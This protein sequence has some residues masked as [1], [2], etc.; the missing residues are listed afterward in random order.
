MFK[1]RIQKLSVLLFHVFICINL[2]AQNT[3]TKSDMS[4]DFGFTRGRNINIWPLFKKYKDSEKKE[5]QI[6][7]PL[8]S[9]MSNYS[10]QTKHSHLLPIF[11]SD[12]TKYSNDIR[13]F[14]FYYPSVFH[15]EITRN[16]KSYK[17]LEL[18]PKITCLGISRN[19]KGLLLENNLF[20]FLWYKHDTTENKT[21]LVAF[22]LYW[23]NSSS[24][25]TSQLFLPF[26]YKYTSKYKSQLNIALLYNYIR[27]YNEIKQSFFPIWWSSREYWDTDTLKRTTIFPIYW[28]TKDKSTNN[29]TYFPFVYYRNKNNFKHLTIFPLFSLG[30]SKDFTKRYFNIYPFYWSN[31]NKVTTNKTFFPFIF[32]LKNSTYQSFT[33][34]PLFS[35]G[36]S[37][38]SSINHFV[39]SPLF[40]HLKSSDKTS[41]IVFPLWWS[42]TSF[43]KNDTTKSKTLFP[44]FWFEK[45]KNA[46]KLSIFPCIFKTK[47]QYNSSF[48]IFPF[49][50]LWKT[51]D[52]DSSYQAFIPFYF[53]KKIP[54]TDIK[55]IFPVI[56]LSKYF[57]KDDTIK[58]SMVFP[59]Y[60]SFKSKIKN[61]KILFPIF[62][63]LSN[64][65]NTSL[66]ILPLF[67]I[68]HSKD[69]T[70]KYFDILPVF[71][72]YKSKERNNTILFPIWWSI[73]K[74]LKND[75]IKK[76]IVFPFVWMEKSSSKNNLIVFPFV[77][78]FNNHNRKSLTVFP[79]YSK[80]KSYLNDSCF[81][82]IFPIYWHI[83]DSRINQHIVFPIYWHTVL[84]KSKDTIRKTSFIPFYWS[85][86]SRNKNNT[87]VF[88]MVYSLKD[89]TKKSLTVF[90]FFS[91]GITSDSSKKYLNIFPF[92]WQQQNKY[93]LSKVLF[94][95]WWQFDNFN[96]H[97]TIKTRTV[98]PFY[99]STHSKS[100]NNTI[101]FPIV[102]NLKNEF[103]RTLTII[104]FF[105]KGKSADSSK[106]Y[107]TVFPIWWQQK[108][109]FQSSSVL[110]P[111]WWKYDYFYKHD[112]IKTRTAFPFFW[113]KKSKTDNNT[114][115]FPFVFKLK[116]ENNSSLTVLPFFSKG[117]TAN[118]KKKYLAI[119]PFWWSNTEVT[120]YDT[121]IHKTFI[122][123][124]WSLK[125][126][127]H[128]SVIIF[129]LFKHTKTSDYKSNILFP[130]F[131]NE[132]TYSKNDTTFKTSLFPIYWSKRSKD[133]NNTVLFPIL[134]KFKDRDYK[135]LTVFPLFS[136][137]Q[138]LIDNSKYLILTPL[139]G[140]IQSKQKVHSYLFPIFNYKREN[141]K[142]QTSVFL[143]LY[144]RKTDLNYSKTSILWPI[145][146]KEKSKNF[147]SF[148][149]API[150]W[151]AKTDTSKMFSIQPFQYSYKSDTRKTFMLFWFLYRYNNVFDK[152]ISHDILWKFFNSE[153]CS[154]GEFETRFLYLLYANSDKD[155]KQE[156][157][158][159]PFYHYVNN[160]NGDKTVS[161]FFGFY[162][163]F[164]QYKSELKA[165]YEEERIFW[166]IRLRSNYDKLKQEGKV[167]DF[168][169]R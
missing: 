39:V 19:S 140:I 47:N 54:N 48:T 51:A 101:L 114:T 27:N 8:F 3:E 78:K 45:S 95:L 73:D 12:S 17:F 129:P 123:F 83:K 133:V 23:Y 70:K 115:L 90:P 169:R 46:S 93:Q 44:I 159:F 122:P 121:L 103:E 16:S 41:N 91:K 145:C 158:I 105:S 30:H 118:S 92:W 152:S 21:R 79:F 155:G 166:L 6:L 167:T 26:Y 2:L 141:T 34:F 42:K 109:K 156:K 4:F 22:P 64:K 65:Q 120:L 38:D 33:F 20:F 125:S 136:K 110:F 29:K 97:D 89:S 69:S 111:L 100:E 37:R 52:M 9:K 143:F 84:S 161:V 35:K 61:N 43:L 87:I 71:W 98:F 124:F 116:N 135:S 151:Y 14:S 99:W 24:Y 7:F 59:C 132:V 56:K 81:W 25:D 149:I 15:F 154:N 63:S 94:P 102:F 131:K 127:H 139:A 138:S 49:Y 142:T 5:L 162:N 107:L 147:S 72:Y 57:L 31:K 77:Y 75:T 146:E 60:W 157:S 137:G 68:G 88:P 13:L 117:N 113:S 128:N 66:T 119:F 164:K 160:A 104:P 74:Y 168:K 106:N 150:I 153:H 53:H 58:Q 36:I 55:Y 148:R 96:K 126:N 144:R 32:S 85:T 130:I 112:T 163:Y 11:I 62:Y 86:K 80:W 40:W 18:A 76:R 50:T 67:S 1:H 10:L 82:T 134:Y 28:S 165:F 108:N